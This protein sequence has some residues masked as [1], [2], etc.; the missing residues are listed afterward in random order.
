MQ[1]M[2]FLKS[3]WLVFGATI[4]GAI[5]GYGYFI[6][7]RDFSLPAHVY[8]N[9]LVST[10]FGTGLG[11]LFGLKIRDAFRKKKEKNEEDR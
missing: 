8:G 6:W 5:L 1:S 11:F 3:N 2:K 10:C 7:V 4:L 9:E